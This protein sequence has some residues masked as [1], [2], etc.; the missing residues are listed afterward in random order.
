MDNKA[1]LNKGEMIVLV[2]DTPLNE[3]RLMEILADQYYAME[4]L[5]KSLENRICYRV[6]NGV[7][8]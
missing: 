1:E 7:Q 8:G 5:V 6:F 3:E 4:D 2:K